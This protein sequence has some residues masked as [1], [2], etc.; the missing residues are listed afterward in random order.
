MDQWQQYVTTEITDAL[1]DDERMLEIADN[2]VRM[3]SANLIPDDISDRLFLMLS[4][5]NLGGQ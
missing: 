1:G 2:L 5:G 4:I 3:D